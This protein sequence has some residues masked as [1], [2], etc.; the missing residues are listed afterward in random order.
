[1]AK[2]SAELLMQRE[3]RVSFGEVPK[4]LLDHPLGEM[5][6]AMKGDEFLLRGSGEH[7]F[8]YRRGE[9]IRV[10]R[11]PDANIADEALWLNGSVY[12]A[13]A[14]I[15]GLLPI[16]ASA[17]VACGG[18][19]AFAGPPGAGKSTLVA[20]LGK[21]GFPMFCDDTLVLDLADPEAIICLPGHK[22]LKLT[23]AAVALTGA[24]PGEKVSRNV[25]KFYCAPPAGETATAMP[26]IELIFLEEGPEAS[27]R[28][29]SG[30][31]RFE[32]MQ[33]DHYTAHL[34]AGARDFDRQERFEHLIGLAKRI[35]MASFV[36]P[37]DE[38]RFGDDV[39]LVARYLEGRTG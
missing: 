36:R 34:Y 2:T 29:I 9:G 16:H 32:R 27:V 26:M 25:D 21:L 28:P 38:G 20:A 12:A 13:V 6:W 35:E 22:R 19:V 24:E 1:M 10:H 30:F 11:G 5:S 37:R 17:V 15:N 7:F 39:E 33:D 8:F 18:V 31:E 3:T 23:P 4:R 14:S